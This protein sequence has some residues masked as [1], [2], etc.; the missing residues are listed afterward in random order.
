MDVLGIVEVTNI[1]Y[2]HENIKPWHSQC[3]HI[4]L[5]TTGILQG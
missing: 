3:D 5:Y 2:S 1:K 4:D